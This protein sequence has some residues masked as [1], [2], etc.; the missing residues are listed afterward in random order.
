[1]ALTIKNRYNTSL[2]G[3]SIY[4]TQDILDMEFIF[5]C[6]VRITITLMPAAKWGYPFWRKS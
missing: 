2:S 1:M 4:E 5:K 3:K 6:N